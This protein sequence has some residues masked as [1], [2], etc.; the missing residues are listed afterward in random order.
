MYTGKRIKKSGQVTR[1][2]V[3]SYPRDITSTS[4][5]SEQ[6]SPAV[7]PAEQVLKGTMRRFEKQG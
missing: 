2:E 6:F 7:L 1:Q 4:T 3:V 5:H